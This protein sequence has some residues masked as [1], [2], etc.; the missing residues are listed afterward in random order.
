MNAIFIDFS[1]TL[2]TS[3]DFLC[4]YENGGVFPYE[5]VEKR[6]ALLGDICKEFDCKVV[7]ASG[8]KDAIDEETMEIDDNAHWVKYIFSIFLTKLSI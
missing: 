6:I 2:N 5:N 8:A 3:H 4:E 7:V 1:G